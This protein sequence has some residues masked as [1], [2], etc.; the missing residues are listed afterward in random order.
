M[1]PALLQ[2]LALIVCPMAKSFMLKRLR[3]RPQLIQVKSQCQCLNG[4]VLFILKAAP[5]EDSNPLPVVPEIAAEAETAVLKLTPGP[6]VLMHQARLNQCREA[7]LQSTLTMPA[8]ARASR[9][10]RAS[11][12]GAI[13]T[14]FVATDW[15]F[16]GE[17]A[18][19]APVRSV[20]I[21]W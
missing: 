10:T 19:G 8:A 20:D 12:A 3:T 15:A 2:V 14:C 16:G 6:A 9:Q 13:A 11:I 1:A 18:A 4:A 21:A 5:Q 17:G 7:L